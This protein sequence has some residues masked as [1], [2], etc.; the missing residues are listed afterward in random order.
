[1]F[2]SILRQAALVAGIATSC[3]LF[4]NAA[5]ADGPVSGTYRP[6]PTTGLTQYNVGGGAAVYTNTPTGVVGFSWNTGTTSGSISGLPTNSV[7][8]GR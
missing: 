6:L 5:L 8:I 1:M 7:T 2:I 4:A 3:A